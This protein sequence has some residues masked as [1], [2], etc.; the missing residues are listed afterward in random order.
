[1]ATTTSRS[2]TLRLNAD[3]AQDLE[4]LARVEGSSVSEE[5]RSAIA[6]RLAALRN[7]KD[8]QAKLKQ[9]MEQERAVLERLAT[10]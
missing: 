9:L 3:Q 10:R 5:I 6:D 1:M 8:F 2:M 7:D 4:T